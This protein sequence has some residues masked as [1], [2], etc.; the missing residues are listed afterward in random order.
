MSAS[1][2]GF[3]SME[4][5]TEV[6]VKP[7][8]FTFNILKPCGHF[9]YH[10]VYHSEIPHSAHTARLY[11]L[12][13]SQNNQPLL[14][15]TT[16]TDYFFITETKCVYCAVGTESLTKTLG[17]VPTGLRYVL[18]FMRDTKFHAGTIKLYT[19]NRQIRS[20]LSLP[21]AL[22]RNRHIA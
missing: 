6:Y 12:H 21:T 4:F 13:G 16:L 8:S 15:Y 22:D 19:V 7:L 9:M 10:Q 14:P 18:P 3:Y 1:H 2:E 11:V 5:V 17:I 20:D